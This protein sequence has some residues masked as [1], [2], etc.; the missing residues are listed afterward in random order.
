MVGEG[1]PNAPLPTLMTSRQS[2]SK[3]MGE[4]AVNTVQIE[5]HMSKTGVQQE[6][7]A[8][9]RTIISIA[10]SM[11]GAIM[12]GMD[13][14][15]FG[16]CQNFDDFLDSW[17]IGAG[18]GDASSCSHDSHIGA[19][20]NEQWLKGFV[21]PAST[22]ITLGAAAGALFLGPVLSSRFGRRFC[23]SAGAS[24][25][26]L[27]CLFASYLSMRSVAVFF[28]G[29]F[30]TGF[31][32]GVC[33]FALPIYN[34]EM[35]TAG[36]RGR[37][38]SMFQ[39]NVVIGLFIAS[40]ITAFIDDWKIGIMLPGVAGAVVAIAIWF[41]PESPRY[42]MAKS[43]YEA[44]VSML[45]TVR[46]GNVL[47]E[48]E[49]MWQAL[50]AEKAEPKVHLAGLCKDVSIR[51]RT[52][53]ACAI[54]VLQQFTGIN[55]FIFYATTILQGLGV[56]NPLAT[57]CMMNGAHV[58]GILVGIYLIDSNSK[59]GG[60]RNMLILSALMMALPMF[61]AAMA[62]TWSWSGV[63]VVV[64]VIIYS[65]S[66][67]VAWG[68]VPWVY[69]S[70]IFSQAERDA[71]TGLAVGM[72]YGANAVIVFITPFLVSWSI[73]GSLALFGVLNLLIAAFCYQYVTETKGVP[74]ELVPALFTDAGEK[75]VDVEDVA[76]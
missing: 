13:Q 47:P 18:Y 7:Q 69:A 67:E 38:G 52:F 60:R 35:S 34:S 58:L 37:T 33:T 24:I 46:Q 15:N 6:G 17:C 22:L 4:K 61:I 23:I 39:L 44:G 65:F 19:I 41:M 59:F 21:D 72:E 28:V 50:E 66:F 48:A 54:M 8:N 32:V 16:Q 2:Q 5:E 42:V 71:A 26:C 29:R 43:G 68:P 73:K 11:V 74:V 51:W 45:R 63:I 56:R 49:G 75:T 55:F 36:I 40:L 1:E 9:A 70:E 31:G 30:V 64:M 76:A 3:D 62:V 53:L 12:F 10:V 27:G 57:N 14:A 20:K 25:C